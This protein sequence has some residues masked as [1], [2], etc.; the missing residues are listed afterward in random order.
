MFSKSAALHVTLPYCIIC[1][2]DICSTHIT[3]LN[4]EKEQKNDNK[5]EL[6]YKQ[7]R[8]FKTVQQTN[9]TGTLDAKKK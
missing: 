8:N 9:K 7:N 3:K 5:N 4:E 2:S 1:G 6:K